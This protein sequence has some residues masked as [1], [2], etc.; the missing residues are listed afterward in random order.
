MSSYII[1]ITHSYQYYS[2]WDFTY[3]YIPDTKETMN[4]TNSKP[5][6]KIQQ[7]GSTQE[8]NLQMLMLPKP[9]LPVPTPYSEN[10]Q[11]GLDQ[12]Q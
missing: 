1:L 3:V 6:R 12:Q 5:V 4:C 8:G 10:Q 11:W 9:Y 7:L 2:M